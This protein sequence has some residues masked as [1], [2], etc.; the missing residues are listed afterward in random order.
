MAQLDTALMFDKLLNRQDPNVDLPL[1]YIPLI[2][3]RAVLGQGTIS[4][5][6]SLDVVFTQ[7]F[8]LLFRLVYKWVSGQ[9]LR[10]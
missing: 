9:T 10:T 1:E 7:L 4:G 2:K 6:G 5:V 3:V 8:I